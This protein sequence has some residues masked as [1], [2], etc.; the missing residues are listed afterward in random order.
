[1]TR[2]DAAGMHGRDETSAA[3]GTRE[4]PGQPDGPGFFDRAGHQVGRDAWKE[5]STEMSYVQLA[6]DVRGYGTGEIEIVTF[7]LGLCRPE[8]QPAA[9]FR[10]L[11][12]GLVTSGRCLMWTWDSEHAAVAGHAALVHWVDETGADPS[13]VPHVA[14]R[15]RA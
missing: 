8:G 7:W 9:A 14:S 11:A 3:R 15:G 6:R 10:T 12:D 4:A 13:R 1:M 2:A 5:L